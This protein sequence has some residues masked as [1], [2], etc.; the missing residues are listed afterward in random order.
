MYMLCTYRRQLTARTPRLLRARRLGS[1]PKRADAAPEAAAKPLPLPA[2]PPAAAAHKP[3]PPLPKQAELLLVPRGSRANGG[4]SNGEEE[5]ED[6]S[7]APSSPS[8]PSA[9]GGTDAVTQTTMAV[10]S[11]GPLWAWLPGPVAR[12]LRS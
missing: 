3:P 10:D 2:A 9:G 8:S 4:M 7:S 12:R 5:E 11:R 1:S 6:A